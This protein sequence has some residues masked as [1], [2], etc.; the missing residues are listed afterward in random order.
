M[1]FIHS[2]LSSLNHDQLFLSSEFHQHCH[3]RQLLALVLHV[4]HSPVSSYL[5]GSLSSDQCIP[6]QKCQPSLGKQGTSA[7]RSFLLL[8]L[9]LLRQGTDEVCMNQTRE[10]TPSWTLQD[11]FQDFSFPLFTFSSIPIRNTVAYLSKYFWYSL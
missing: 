11:M 3:R 1:P 7:R 5:D 9:Q 6:V 4:K 10:A 2:S 8:H